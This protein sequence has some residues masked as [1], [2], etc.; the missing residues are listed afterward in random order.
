MRMAHPSRHPR[1]YSLPCVCFVCTL[2]IAQ[3]YRANKKLMY[4]FYV[5]HLR[6]LL[7]LSQLFDIR[8]RLLSLWHHLLSLLL[9]WFNGMNY[10]AYLSCC[11]C[12][13]IDQGGWGVVASWHT[14]NHWQIGSQATPSRAKWKWFRSRLGCSSREW[15]ETYSMCQWSSVWISVTTIT[16]DCWRSI[17]YLC[18]SR[19][20]L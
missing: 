12:C 18:C 14:Y 10:G 8:L 20:L 13:N 16:A 6:F 5:W 7:F 15:S 4:S 17:E 3:Q 1:S 2:Y 11:L 9:F 19:P